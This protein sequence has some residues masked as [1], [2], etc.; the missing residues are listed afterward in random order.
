MTEVSYLLVNVF[1]H[2]EDSPNSISAGMAHPINCALLAICGWRF[3]TLEPFF[4]TI[5]KS[6]LVFTNKH[7]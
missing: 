2:P 1:S 6:A 7:R 5:T 3:L 4:S